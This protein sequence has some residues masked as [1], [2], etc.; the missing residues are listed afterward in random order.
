MLSDG[1]GSSGGGGG[2]G[3]GKGGEFIE[4]EAAREMRENVEYLLVGRGE[5]EEDDDQVGV[6][7][8]GGSVCGVDRNVYDC[9]HF[10]YPMYARRRNR[11]VAVGHSPS[12][13]Y[14]HTPTKSVAVGD[15]RGGDAE[16]G[17]VPDRQGQGACAIDRVYIM[18]YVS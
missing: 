11:S 8:C 18:L 5:G 7:G 9:T 13:K 2:G 16:D 14:K 12:N 6:C 17:H 3:G 1:G 4:G 15:P 10:N